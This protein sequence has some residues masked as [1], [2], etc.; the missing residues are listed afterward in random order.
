VELSAQARAFLWTCIRHDRRRRGRAIT[1]LSALLVVALGLAAFSFDRQR[2]AEDRQR[3][4]ITRQLLAQAEIGLDE[5]PRTALRLNEAAVRVHP[6]QETRSALVNNLLTTPYRATLT[7]HDGGTYAVDFAPDGNIL[8]SAGNDG[9]ARLWNLTDPT[10]PTPLGPPLT[11]QDD[12]IITVAFASDEPVLATA[13]YN[14][15]VRLWNVSGTQWLREHAMERA[16]AITSG[17]LNHD[18]WVIY[19]SDLDYVDVCRS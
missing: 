4:A 13:G 10:A 12:Q 14:G 17:G 15:T 7:G 9:T 3:L 6:S 11:D 16:C 19:V 18:E 8:A 2:A 5:D 1:I